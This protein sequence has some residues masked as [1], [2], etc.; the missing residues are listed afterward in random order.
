MFEHKHSKWQ[1]LME[2]ARAE[3][4]PCLPSP[5]DERDWPL[6]RITLPIRLPPAVRLDYLV[7][8]V[9]DQGGCG[10]CVGKA[11]MNILNAYYNHTQ[12]LPDEGLSSLFIYARCKQEDGVPDTEGTYPR[13]ALKIAQKEGACPKQDLPYSSWIKQG[14]CLD[15][16]QITDDMK[17]AAKMHRI[18]AYARLQD[19]DGYTSLA[20]IKE[21]LAAGKLV[22]AGILVTG[23]FM[24]ITKWSN[25]KVIGPPGGGIYGLHAVCLCGYDN[26]M[27]AVRGVNSWGSSWGDKGYF[28]LSY[29]FF[30]WRDDIGMPAAWEAWAVE[31][32]QVLEPPEKIELWINQPKARVNGE[33]VLIDPANPSVVPKILE[34]RTMLPARFVAEALGRKVDWDA[35]ERK[36]TIE[37]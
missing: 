10:T 16:P 18:K 13:V 3:K 17:K 27:Q 7:P 5:P 23:S 14:N 9:P 30:N 37:K 25:K 35:K 11:T 28:W 15:M 33:E 1:Q 29:D 34:G 12:Q 20:Q 8:R 31:F 4:W 19:P 21:A 26:N 22:L 24:D 6:S 2:K 36:V 32:E